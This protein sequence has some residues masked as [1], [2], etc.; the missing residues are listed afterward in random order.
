M[1]LTD[2]KQ[3]RLKF[4]IACLVVSFGMALWEYRTT[5]IP[6]KDLT[7]PTS[8]QVEIAAPSE[9]LSQVSTVPSSLSISKRP[10]L[11]IIEIAKGKKNLFYKEL[12]GYDHV[13]IDKAGNSHLVE[14]IYELLEQLLKT[15]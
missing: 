14:V 6:L 3:L 11:Q 2:N 1:I 12:D 8:L 15:K 9:P 5:P 10:R 4:S 7:P 13:Y